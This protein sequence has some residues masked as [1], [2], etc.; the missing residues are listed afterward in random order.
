[1][2]RE[3]LIREVHLY[4]D[5]RDGWDGEGSKAP[6]RDMVNQALVLCQ[7]FPETLLPNC[8]ISSLGVIGFYWKIDT[9]YADIENENGV[10]TFLLL[11]H[12]KMLNLLM[13]LI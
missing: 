9:F 8:M 12:I 2:T 11:L 4:G 3:A 1:M 5:F 6:S 10:F 13:N 7:R